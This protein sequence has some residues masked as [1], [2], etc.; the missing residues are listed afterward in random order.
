MG[1]KFLAAALCALMMLSCC[2]FASAEATVE[3]RCQFWFDGDD[4]ANWQKIIDEFEA[5]NPGIRVTLESTTW[6]D[7]W[8]KLQT[9]AT[10]GTVADVFG[11]VSMYSQ[12]YMASGIAMP[13]KQFAEGDEDF[14]GMENYY[15]AI[16][17]AYEYN[18]D[19][20]FL[21]YDMSTMLLL[22]NKDVL[23][24]CGIEFK[25]EGYTKEEIEAMAPALK[26]KGYYAIHSAGRTDWTYYD[27]LTRA[28]CDI[29]DEDGKLNLNQEGV[30]QT[31]QWYADMM[32]QGY[33]SY[34]TDKTDYF[35][36]GMA[37]MAIYNP[38]GVAGMIANM[39]ADLDVI[40]AY[41]TDVE[42]GKVIAEGGAY[43]IYSGTAHPEEA[44]KLAKAMTD[45]NASINIV[46]GTFRGVPTVNAEDATAAF[47]KSTNAPEH[48]Q[49]FLD[50]LTNSSRPD[51]PNRTAVES[52]M[53][54]Y[55]QL[56]YGGD[57][58]AAEGLAEFQEVADELMAE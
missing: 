20:Y 30:V 50:L 31:T 16:L 34:P 23:A 36:S 48:A 7:Y 26:E 8:T 40:A 6:D 35:A 19:F 49:F 11:M 1:K 51:Y 38:E 41:P 33:F 15:E 43:G 54:N 53:R 57:M 21:P 42:G 55:L 17:S 46:A 47:L 12:D 5:A 29:I 27:V 56:I 28:G 25:P 32:E 39:D 9:Q 4:L 13:M 52:E 14:I 37:A 58:T 10:S 18:D 24:A 3:L 44:W 2:A 22:V 45:A